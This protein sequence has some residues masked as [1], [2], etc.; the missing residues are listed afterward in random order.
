[1]SCILS[2]WPSH[3]ILW[4]LI[5]IYIY[6]FNKIINCILIKWNYYTRCG[7]SRRVRAMRKAT[8]SFITSVCPHGTNHL[9]LDGFSWQ[10]LCIFQ[11][12]SRKFKF[13]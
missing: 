11:N 13:H 8:V 10:Y 9:P 6:I 2:I 4:H 12:L 5:N 1:V 7:V 3:R